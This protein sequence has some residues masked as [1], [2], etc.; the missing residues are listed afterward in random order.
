MPHS[1]VVKAAYV[2]PEG[3]VTRMPGKAIYERPLVVVAP[4]VAV[5]KGAAFPLSLLD[6]SR[7]LPLKL[8][9]AFPDDTTIA[10]VSSSR[11][12]SPS[13]TRIVT[14]RKVAGPIEGVLYGF[15]PAP[16]P[17]HTGKGLYPAPLVLPESLP[18]PVDERPRVEVFVDN[19]NI[20]YSF[21]NWLRA[22]PE[23]QY[24]SFGERATK[25]V[26]VGGKKAQLDYT[27]LFAILERGRK[28]ERRVLIGS[29]PLWQGL[30]TAVEWVCLAL[31]LNATAAEVAQGY[32]VSVLQRVPRSIAPPPRPIARR[33]AAP[34]SLGSDYPLASDAVMS[35]TDTETDGGV[36]PKKGRGKKGTPSSPP[37]LR[38][39]GATLSRMQYKEQVCLAL[40]RV[41][42]C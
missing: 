20:M 10:S 32:E 1:V 33:V 12:Y 36:N 40:L 4:P 11:L 23:A 22:R 29:S 27:T 37:A 41:A 24:Q 26:V 18:P 14:D 38:S 5:V 39:G 17:L 30:D 2:R 34:I 21:L 19:S 8:E 25:T 9:M 16:P 28:V 6:K 15:W 42:R 7:S 3:G 31:H 13:I 35:N